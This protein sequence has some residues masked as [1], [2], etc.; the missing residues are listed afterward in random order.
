MEYKTCSKCASQSHHQTHAKSEL[1]L[2]F[3]FTLLGID[4]LYYSG[5]EFHHDPGNAGIIMLVTLHS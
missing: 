5:L 2:F 3:N 1:L 4:F